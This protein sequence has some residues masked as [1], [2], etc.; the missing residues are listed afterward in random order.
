V[1]L[2]FRPAADNPPKAGKSNQSRAT[3]GM[4]AEH[5]NNSKSDVNTGNI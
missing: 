4:I 1:L 3:N 5:Y 2:P